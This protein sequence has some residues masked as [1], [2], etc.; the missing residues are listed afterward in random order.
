MRG[1]STF[2]SAATSMLKQRLSWKAVARDAVAA[3]STCSTMS[4]THAAMH[5]SLG[6]RC[7]AGAAPSARSVLSHARAAACHTRAPR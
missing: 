4:H 3:T 2:K 7:R 5:Q 6:W 1:S